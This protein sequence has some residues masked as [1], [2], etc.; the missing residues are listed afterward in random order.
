MKRFFFIRLGC[1]IDVSKDKSHIFFGGYTLD[2]DFKCISSKSVKM[3]AAEIKKAVKW[4]LDKRQKADP[5]GQLPFQ[6]V[7]ESTSRY[8]EK[9]LY[10][11]HEAELPVCLPQTRLLKKYM[12][13]LPWNSK[14]DPLDAKGLAHFACCRKA[15]VW[16]P[17]SKNIL[18]LRDLLRARKALKEKKV[19]LKNQ[20]HAISYAKF[21]HKEIERS[22][23]RLVK[24]IEREID[25]LETTIFSLYE[26]DKVLRE[27][28]API[29]KAVK[30][31]GLI[32][33]LTVAAETN[34]F[35]KANSRKELAK[36][37]GY[38]I[39][40]NQSGRFKGKTHISKRG[41]KHIRVA[42][43]MASVSHILHGEGNIIKAYQRGQA[44]KP[45]IYKHSNVIVQRKLLL[46]I[47]TL[48]T[49]GAV[50]DPYHIPTQCQP[51]ANS[52]STEKESTPELRS[53]VHE[54]ATSEE[55]L[56]QQR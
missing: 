46:L 42:M 9:L 23:K 53:E 36:Y 2:G 20:I 27:K 4:I 39:V 38:D 14:N 51:Q 54:I 3:T 24:H 34:G 41:N 35:T 32:T 52:P 47:H 8:H 43:Y 33:V 15:K 13:S 10:A 19:A 37:A 28:I 48:W 5:D 40:E 22:Y 1:G 17:F 11:L 18:Q 56:L 45:D 7:M 26:E 30:G 25:K 16:A 6:I 44:K 55:V 50:Y 29:V 21:T 49:T 12:D 31:L